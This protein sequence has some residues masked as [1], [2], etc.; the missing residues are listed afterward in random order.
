MRRNTQQVSDF[1]KYAPKYYSVPNILPCL[2]QLVSLWEILQDSYINP[3][4]E[5]SIHIEIISKCSK[6]VAIIKL[7][8][9][10]QSV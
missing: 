8:N 7:K 10:T 6:L 5:V 1:K 4:A 9:E 3:H 2:S